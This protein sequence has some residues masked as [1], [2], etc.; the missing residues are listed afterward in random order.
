MQQ[1]SVVEDI[2]VFVMTNM[3]S[4]KIDLDKHIITDRINGDT[5]HMLVEMTTG[6]TVTVPEKG[7]EKHLNK[8]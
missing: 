2:R 6:P 4:P 3:N 8:T 1:V 5:F 7:I